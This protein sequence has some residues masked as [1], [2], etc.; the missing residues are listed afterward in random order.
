MSDNIFEEYDL[1]TIKL[2]MNMKGNILN[3]VSG[4][5][6]VRLMVSER[7]VCLHS[8]CCSCGEEMKNISQHELYELKRK[9]PGM[10]GLTFFEGLTLYCTNSSLGSFSGH[11]LR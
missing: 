9:F 10:Q 6:V 7:K 1:R 3:I 5:P 4:V 8:H 11:N 2:T